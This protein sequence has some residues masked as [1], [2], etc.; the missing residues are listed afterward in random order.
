MQ[1]IL[2]LSIFLFKLA[3][4]SV[5]EDFL[6]RNSKSTDYFFHKFR[7]RIR[8]HPLEIPADFH[9]STYLINGSKILKIMDIH[10]LFQFSKFWSRLSNKLNN[11]NRREFGED[12]AAMTWR[13]F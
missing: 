11:E 5:T 2:E 4:I 12:G 13:L 7:G 8:L 6:L 9:Y 10:G 3:S 1:Q